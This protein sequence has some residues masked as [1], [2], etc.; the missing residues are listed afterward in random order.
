LGGLFGVGERGGGVGDLDG[1]GG[2]RDGGSG[3]IGAAAAGVG[4]DGLA[5]IPYNPTSSSSVAL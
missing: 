4:G 2:D 3:G 5:A 1:G